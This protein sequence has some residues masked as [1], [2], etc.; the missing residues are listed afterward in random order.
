MNERMKQLHASLDAKMERN[1]QL[2]AAAEN[3]DLSE[4]ARAEAREAWVAGLDEVDSIQADIA[5]ESRAMEQ[6]RKRKAAVG[7]EQREQAGQEDRG[8]SFGDRVLRS[9]EPKLKGITRGTDRYSISAEE[10]RATVTTGL[11]DYDK[12]GA[13]QL[14]L[15]RPTVASLLLSGQISGNGYTYFQEGA[16]TGGPAGTAEAGEKPELSGQFTQVNE[17]LAKIAGITKESD[18][19]IEDFPALRSVVEG[20][21]I[22][23]L[24]LKEDADLLNGNGTAPNIRGLLNRTGVQTHTQAAGEST[25][26]AIFKAITKVQT[27]TFMNADF[28]VINPADYEALRLATDD[29][30]QYYGGG[31][32]QGQYGNGGVPTMPGLWG[33]RTVVTSAIAAGTVLVGSGQAAQVFRKGGVRVDIA[34]QNEDDFIHDLVTIRAEV[35]L[36]LAVYMPAAFVK[37]TLLSE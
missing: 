29:N 24:A 14:P 20:R 21:L 12:G 37:V 13:V 25:Q 34:N 16:V 15:E 1:A 11:T 3:E 22:T 35:R 10:V 28:V 17:H 18:E 31:F 30:G 26:D 4:S 8:G 36:L 2:Q 33:L 23:R 7:D 32:F 19:L 5:N 27:A 6:I 9:L